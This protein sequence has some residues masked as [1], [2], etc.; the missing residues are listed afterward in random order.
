MTTTLYRVYDTADGLLYVGISDGPFLR[1]SA[2]ASAGW[3]AH[4]A[5]I[6]L[7]QYSDRETAASAELSAIQ[8][9]DPVWNM[10]GRPHERFMQWMAAYPDKNP[11]DIDV[12][13]L[14]DKALTALLRG[15][16]S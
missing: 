11:D 2:H 5:K 10:A 3:A 12:E 7:K 4:A 8:G 6:T 16:A 9:E 15:A 13:E 1:L 14:C